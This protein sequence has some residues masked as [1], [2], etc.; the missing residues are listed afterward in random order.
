MRKCYSN[1]LTAKVFKRLNVDRDQIIIDQKQ[2]L[3]NLRNLIKY[4]LLQI[5]D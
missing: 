4:N 5:P 1:F 3:W 2:R